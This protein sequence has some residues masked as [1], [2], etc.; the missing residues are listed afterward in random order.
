MTWQATTTVLYLDDSM[1]HGL[2]CSPEMLSGVTEADRLG[3]IQLCSLHPSW[4]Q[5][6]SH[7]HASVTDNASKGAI[8]D[9]VLALMKEMENSL[10]EAA[11]GDEDI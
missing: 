7:W 8:Q 6:G 11:A 1:Q 9:H 4:I 3:S 10:R 5:G 2:R